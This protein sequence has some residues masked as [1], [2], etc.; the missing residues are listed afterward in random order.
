MYLV[1][2]NVFSEL[3]KRDADPSVVAWFSAQETLA[4][5]AITLEELA[6]G[7]ERARPEHAPRLRRWLE[8][9]LAIPPLVL[10][11]DDKVARTAGLLRASQ[12]A[13]G[14]TVAQADML[15]AATAITTGRILVTR[16]VKDFA[17]CG[18]P[19][20]NPFSPRRRP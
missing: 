3:P 15:I 14:H 8:Q 5:S 18:V 2:T 10:P 20:L 11:V 4:M 6:F 17:G 12:E 7:V 19:V 9:L 1:D 16:N 13:S